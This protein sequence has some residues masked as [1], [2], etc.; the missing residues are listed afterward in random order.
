M[1]IIVEAATSFE[2]VS[3]SG[4]T[5]VQRNNTGLTLRLISRANSVVR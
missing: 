3:D 5:F 4:R 1:G 2:G